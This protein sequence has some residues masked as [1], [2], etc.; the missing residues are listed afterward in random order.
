MAK[1]SKLMQDSIV[2]NDGFEN[3]LKGLGTVKDPRTHTTFG[4][5]FI[6]TQAIANNLYT[7][8][9][10]SAKIVD[11]PIDDATRKW[12]TLL[13]SDADEKAEVEEAM[14][15]LL[16]KDRVNIA[17]K[18]ARVYGGSVIIAI[19]DGEDPEEPLEMERIRPD[20]LKNFVVL[21]RWNITSGAIDRD[22]M[23]DNFGQPEYYT[24]A[25][26]GQKIHHTR[27]TKFLGVQSTIYEAEKQNF[28]GDSIFTRLWAAVSDSE[29]VSN[30]IANLIHESN[31]DVYRINEFNALVAEGNDELVIK[32]LKLAHEMKSI[33][34]GIAL[35][36][37]DEYDKKSNTFQNLA[38]IDDRF[39]Q[40]V[41][42]AAD[43]PVTR[44]LGKSPAGQNATGESD[45]LNYYDNVQSI[46]EN[47]LRP[48]L[49]WI[50]SIVMASLGKSEEQLK[51][52]F[53][54]LK[55]L[56]EIEQ[57]QVD[58]NNAQRDDIYLN[59]GVITEIDSLSQLAEDGTYVSINENRVQEE[60]KQREID[61]EEFGKE[62]EEEE[63]VNEP[64]EK[65][66]E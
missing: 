49:E 51:F 62:E 9:W 52:A 2:I 17:S 40:K 15:C 54:P 50:D 23:S 11:I 13:I 7:Y 65:E 66:E 53:N 57:A 47:Y 22:I 1:I 60:E 30:S 26:N 48:K 64:K 33:I 43:I 18:W 55:Q 8:N 58:L 14:K 63:E 24:V 45:M 12:R 41:A 31:V 38:N 44:L 29:T 39:I 32:R 6:I 56:T 37:E 3:V 19:I 21:D 36:K 42:G 34:N 16:V 61:L 10:L 27:L 35:D 25:R 20:T 4:T 46:Q 5:G 28:W 59:Q